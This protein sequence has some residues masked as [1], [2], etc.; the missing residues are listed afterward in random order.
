MSCQV[1]VEDGRVMRCYQDQLRP[2]FT[3]DNVESHR[4]PLLDDND[5]T[6]FT[7]APSPAITPDIEVTNT[8]VERRYPSH[9]HRPAIQYRE[10]NS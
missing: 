3:G 5:L 10:G 4:I 8:N 1:K 9:V 7:S 6:M 2:R